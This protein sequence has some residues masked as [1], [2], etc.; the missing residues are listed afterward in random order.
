MHEY[1]RT[2][3]FIAIKIIAIYHHYILIVIRNIMIMYDCYLFEN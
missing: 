3:I 2:I 1:I